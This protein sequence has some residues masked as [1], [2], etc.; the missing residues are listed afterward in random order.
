MFSKE[1][2]INKFHKIY[3]DQLHKVL[4]DIDNKVLDKIKNKIIDKIKN[5][6]NIFVCGNGGSAAIANHYVCDYLKLIRENTIYKPKFF[7]LNSNNELISAISNDMDYKKIFSYQL[8]TYGKKDDLL[9]L[10]SSSGN[11]KNIMEALKFCKSKKIYTIG[12][13]GFAG[14]YLN[15]N[16]NLSLHIKAKHYGLSEDSHHI[17]MHL[18]MQNIIYCLK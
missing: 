10:I 8:E 13:S 7:S 16:S 6:K 1:K 15:K 4:M 18:I 12:F 3:I 5:Q 11:S 9:I 2:D 17:F 14:G